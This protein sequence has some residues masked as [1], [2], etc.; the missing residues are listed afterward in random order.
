M[1][2]AA[3]SDTYAVVSNK[4]DLLFL[5]Y[6]LVSIFYLENSLPCLYRTR[7]MV[8]KYMTYNDHAGRWELVV[9]QA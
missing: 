6:R 9:E 5:K 7:Y 2:I 3:M 1:V 8:S 4:A